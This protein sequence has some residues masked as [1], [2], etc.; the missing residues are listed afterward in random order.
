MEPTNLEKILTA[1]FTLITNGSPLHSLVVEDG[2][3]RPNI[4]RLLLR[5]EFK[6][7][8]PY[9]NMDTIP[10]AKPSSILSE[11]DLSRFDKA[12]F[13]VSYLDPHKY[14]ASPLLL[15]DWQK[16][17][18]VHTYHI[19]VKADGGVN[20]T[21]VQYDSE[22]ES[23]P[24]AKIRPSTCRWLKVLWYNAQTG[25]TEEPSI[26]PDDDSKLDDR[27]ED[28]VIPPTPNDRAAVVS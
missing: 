15:W 1:R 3:I 18:M 17:N 14:G 16:L 2:I 4:A 10:L 11:Y 7:V 21:I 8:I 9:C 19:N 26:F 5:H 20:L 22:K 25:K 23:S 12:R 13:I 27:E 28:W 24:L 6:D